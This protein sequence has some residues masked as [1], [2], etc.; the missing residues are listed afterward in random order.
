MEKKILRLLFFLYLSLP[1]W[2]FSQKMGSDSLIHWVFTSDA[3]YGITRKAFRGDTSVPAFKVNKAM[4]EAINALPGT[5]LPQDQG[6]ESGK[7]IER[8]D[9]LFETGDIANRMEIPIQSASKSWNQFDRD[10]LHR[11]RLKAKNGK[12][13]QVIMVPGNHDISNA[14]GFAKPMLPLQD[15]TSMVKIYNLMMKPTKQLTNETYSYPRDR[16][17]FSKNIEGIHFM[18][19]TLWADSAQRIW[20][21]KDLD[22]VNSKTPVIL[23]CHDQPAPEAKHFTN[24]VPPYN[25]TLDNHFENLLEEKYKEGPKATADGGNSDIEQKGLTAFLKKHPNFK[26]YFHGNNNWNEFYTYNG[27][28]KDLN[29]PVFRVDSPMKGRYSSKDETKLSFQF[30]CL[31]AKNLKLT[32]REILWNTN[33]KN[34]KPQIAFGNS[35]TISLKVE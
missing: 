22:S 21:E 26:A 14:I 18:F 16:I 9:Y 12:P 32:A 6:L 25:M 17:N 27:T 34:K 23:F 4:I 29:L 11:I 30:I 15:P 33:P 28:D 1:H 7:K 19:I 24:P 10:Y 2:V 13:L 5:S 35:Q 20:M 8:I 3:H 31:D